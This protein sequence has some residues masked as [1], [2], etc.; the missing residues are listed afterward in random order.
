MATRTLT[1]FRATGSLSVRSILQQAWTLAAT[2]VRARQTRQLLV[3]MDDRMLA[4][5]GASRS[6]AM[7]EAARPFWAVTP[8]RR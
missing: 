7:M 4:D 6:D 1:A 8:G 5:V 3:E 2:M